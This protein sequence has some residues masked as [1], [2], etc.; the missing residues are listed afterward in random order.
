MRRGRQRIARFCAAALAALGMVMNG[1]ATGWAADDS[2]IVTTVPPPAQGGAAEATSSKPTPGTTPPSATAKPQTGPGKPAPSARATAAKSPE[3][4]PSAA[5]AAGQTP[6]APKSAPKRGSQSIAAL[7]NDEPITA[8]EIE[9]RQRLIGLNANI[10]DEVKQRFNSLVK[11]PEVTERLKRILNETINA[12][13]GKSK[14]EIIAI[15]EQRKKEYAQSLQRQAIESARSKTLPGLRKQ[16]LEELIDEH[17]KMQ[18]AR[19][20]NAVADDQ[21]VDRIL[22]GMAERNKMTLEQF[23][24]HMR[25]SG[26]DIGSMRSRLKAELSWREVVRRRFGHQVA[27]T[28]RDV[29]RFVAA[30]P[31]VAADDV[32][33]E[34]QRITLKMPAKIDQRLV[35]KRVAE[36][37][38][39]ATRFTGCAGARALAAG[40]A[41]VQHEDLG[42]RKASTISEPTRSLL[43]NARDGEILPPNVAQGG[44]ELWIL[45]GRT[46]TK[47]DDRKREVAQ[48]ELRQ[49]EFEILAKKH[50][51]DLRLDAAIEYR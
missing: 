51:K 33:L 17:L 46:A 4:K 37:E 14:D 41:D 26:A 44:V 35:A 12:N 49:K 10:Q 13:K 31:G 27:I 50:L 38:G 45:C 32:A 43:L 39:L 15:F 30:S 48:A 42:S 22:T 8:Y 6:A 28:E 11:S 9:Q 3:A 47:G 20:L 18:E 23:A 5:N 40:L 16:A 29:D 25:S 21:E 19:R 34:V 24:A 2:V 1:P 7:V 36:A